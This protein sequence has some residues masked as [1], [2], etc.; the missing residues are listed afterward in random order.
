LR[1]CTFAGRATK[2]VFFAAGVSLLLGVNPASAKELK[3]IGVSVGSLNYPFFGSIAKGAEFEA[4]KINPNVR[5]TAVEHYWDPAT[6]NAQIDAFIAAGVDLIVL[7]PSDPNAIEPAIDRAH[8]GGV[9]VV[10]ADS[11]TAGADVTIETNNVQAGA[12]ACEYLVEKMGG[13]GAVL[14]LSFGPTRTSASDRA[15]GC[16]DVV[17]KHP[18]VKILP[19][20]EDTLGT[21]D[22]G[23]AVGVALLGR[24]PQVDGVFALS[25]FSALGMAAAAKK[26]NRVNFPITAVDGTPEAV[27]A[28]KDPNTPQFVGTASQD[29]FLMGRLAV[30]TGVKILGGKKP[31][32]DLVE[33]DSKMV[34]RDNVNEY[35]GWTSN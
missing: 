28:L 7:S 6:Q 18:D 9:P 27:Q 2:G 15:K 35:K 3:S 32:R 1:H 24:F 11:R 8:K 33:M 13:K 14:I 34:T 19:Q 16:S 30:Q 17:A 10:A 23:F 22:G 29:P 20:D 25:D 5:I 4:R 26:L 21:R 12:V 31:D